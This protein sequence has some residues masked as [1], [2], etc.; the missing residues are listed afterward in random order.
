MDS[1]LGKAAMASIKSDIDELSKLMVG[2]KLPEILT[3]FRDYREMQNKELAID[4]DL[5]ERTVQRYLNG[6]N[7]V[8]DKRTLIALC[9]GLR[10]RYPIIIAKLFREAGIAFKE[11]DEDDNALSMVL[12]SMPGHDIHCVNKTLINLGCEPLT[13]KKL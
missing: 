7:R 11:N 4:S 13:K 9:I 5:D 1:P 6:E 8:P 12:M 3:K 10:V 2:C